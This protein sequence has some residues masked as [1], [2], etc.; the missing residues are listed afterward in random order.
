M[1]TRGSDGKPLPPGIR[2]G[3]GPVHHF[4]GYHDKPPWDATGCYLLVNR[5]GAADRQPTAADAIV[6]GMV[7]TQERDEYLQFGPTRVWGWQQG[8]MLQW[9]GTPG[10]RQ[11]IDNS[12]TDGRPTADVI[13]TRNRT[14]VTKPTDSTTLTATPPGGVVPQP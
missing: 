6:V 9:P 12:V 3:C 8:T 7:D 14:L 13:D 11:V 10:G 2:R 5:V 1:P 4:L